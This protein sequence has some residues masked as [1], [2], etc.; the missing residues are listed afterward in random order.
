MKKTEFTE[1]QILFVPKQIE[2][3]MVPSVLG[4]YRRI[5]ADWAFPVQSSRAPIWSTVTR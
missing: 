2:V 1:E 3:L 5:A 4:V